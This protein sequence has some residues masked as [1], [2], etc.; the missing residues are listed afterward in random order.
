MRTVST[1]LMPGGELVRPRFTDGTF[2]APLPLDEHF[3]ERFLAPEAKP[4]QLVIQ[5]PRGSGLTTALRSL[6]AIA[7]SP[8]PGCRARA[9]VLAADLLGGD[10]RP[11]LA[12]LASGE[13]ILFLDLSVTPF[14]SS[15]PRLQRF[16]R[17]ADERR[18]LGLES[19][20]AFSIVVAGTDLEPLVHWAR[21][22][23]APRL[24]LAELAPWGDDELLEL[25]GTSPRYLERR[26]QLMAELPPIARGTNLLRLPRTARWIVDAALELDPGTPITLSHLYA[27]VL[28]TLSPGAIEVIKKGGSLARED[29]AA[30]LAETPAL[31]EE[32]A[33]LYAVSPRTT[34]FLLAGAGHV[35]IKRARKD[36][37]PLTLHGLDHFIEAGTFLRAIASG[38]TMN[39][40]VPACP[41]KPAFPF[42][43]EMITEHAKATLRG[44]LATPEHVADATAATV[45]WACGERPPLDA[46][47]GPVNLD[48]AALDLA[49]LSGMQLFASRFKGTELHRASLVG[50]NLANALFDGTEAAGAVFDGAQA[51]KAR[52]FK[53]QLGGASFVKADLNRA[54]FI[55]ARVAG[56]SFAGAEVCDALVSLCDLTN[57]DFA[58]ANLLGGRIHGGTLAGANFSAAVLSKARLAGLDLTTTCFA[59]ASL[60]WAELK[61]CNL[62]GLDLSSVPGEKA[63]FQDCD[64][65]A[66]SFKGAKL[67]L[68][69]FEH[70]RARDVSFVDADLRDARFVNV[71]FHAGS[72]RAGMLLGKPALEGSM[73]GFYVEG[74]TD[75]AWASPESI[76]QAS[77]QGADLRAATFESTNLFRVDFRGAI[78]LPA[79]RAQ[80]LKDGAILDPEA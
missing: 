58:A 70:C 39:V 65:S 49:D 67:G 17:D 61:A 40:P 54:S 32:L 43:R 3:V 25:L 30:A 46:R 29:V 55:M 1:D 41:K 50:A 75:D 66:T 77:F 63:T 80:A 73:T 13:A 23:A 31:V 34:R 62:S 69:R 20:D 10:P 59:V 72:A 71:N 26:A 78:L 79:L 36:R 56:A 28:D 12:K 19:L 52:F 18:R 48:G 74:T 45:L 15:G 6:A 35:K 53:A 24:E 27:N 42:I 47:N 76:R 5:G 33:V 9:A 7:A 60:H 8:P 21:K 51:T 44:W 16:L 64:L 4:A 2:D 14:D 38:P 37:A 11:A 22:R 57:A 68:A